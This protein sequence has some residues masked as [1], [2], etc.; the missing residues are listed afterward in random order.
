M[1]A[2]TAVATAFA[3][4]VILLM[5]FGAHGFCARDAADEATDELERAESIATE[6][7]GEA[8]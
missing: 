3:G 1:G 4:V 5:R 8:H 2:A 6:G 7:K